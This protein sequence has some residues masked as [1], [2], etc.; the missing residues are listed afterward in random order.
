MC[1]CVSH[2]CKIENM[3]HFSPPPGIFNAIKYSDT[4]VW[5]PMMRHKRYDDGFTANV[6]VDRLAARPFVDDHHVHVWRRRAA[7]EIGAF[8]K[9]QRVPAFLAPYA[10][11]RAPHGRFENGSDDGPVGLTT[12]RGVRGETRMGTAGRRRGRTHRTT[13]R[14]VFVFVVRVFVRVV[15]RVVRRRNKTVRRTQIIAPRPAHSTRV[16]LRRSGRARLFAVVTAARRSNRLGGDHLDD[17][18]SVSARART[19]ER[20]S[21]T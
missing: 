2:N 21:T 7:P 1:V 18:R 20:T 17:D 12:R 13:R 10:T 15:V 11:T 8:E 9:V 16:R 3:P 5:P 19:D 6:V 4:I 14:T